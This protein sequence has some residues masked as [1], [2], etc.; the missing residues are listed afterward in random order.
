MDINSVPYISNEIK[1]EIFKYLD[2]ISL[3]KLLHVN[4]IINRIVSTNEDLYLVSQIIKY[5]KLR[6]GYDYFGMNYRVIYKVEI[7]F[8][9]YYEFRSYSI[10]FLKYKKELKLY[11]FMNTIKFD[12]DKIYVNKTYNRQIRLKNSLDIIY[13]YGYNNTY[14]IQMKIECPFLYLLCPK[15]RNVEV[16][17]SHHIL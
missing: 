1:T 12:S 9:K 11:P 16:K 6:I 15:I 10:N 5:M 7:I 3:N 13:I 2:N 4:R 8:N 17:Y 14:T